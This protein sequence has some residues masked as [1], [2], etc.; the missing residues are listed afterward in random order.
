MKITNIGLE[1]L[2]TVNKNFVS[3]FYIDEKGN[4]KKIGLY[5]S[6]SAIV[7]IEKDWQIYCLKNYWSN[8]T[9]KL[10]NEIQPD[11]KQRLEREDF[12]KILATIFE[13][14]GEQK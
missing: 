1:N 6:Y 8:T 10:L 14:G 3:I 13:K 2:G 11:K 4:E 12:D 9:G 7:G 5:F